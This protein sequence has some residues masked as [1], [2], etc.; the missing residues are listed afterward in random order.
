MTKLKIL[1]TIPCFLLLAIDV[2]SQGRRRGATRPATSKPTLTAPATVASPTPTVTASP[3]APVLLATMNGQN[4]TT[5][6]IDARVREEVDRLEEKIA[7]TR[8]QI[9]ETEINTLLLASE[10]SKR[11]ISPQQLYDS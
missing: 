1:L 7:E 4:L 10:A 5:A 9:L 11:R 6:D 3:K 8:R 2:S